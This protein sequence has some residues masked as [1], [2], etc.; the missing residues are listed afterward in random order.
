MKTDSPSSGRAALWSSASAQS[1]DRGPV[2]RGH[3]HGHHMQA[4][5]SSLAETA[6]VTVPCQSDPRA[7]LQVRTRG[8]CCLPRGGGRR[9]SRGQAGELDRYKG[10]EGAWGGRGRGGRQAF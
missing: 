8:T 1:E 3:G 2:S 7:T 10:P 4:C 6:P 5:L 9:R